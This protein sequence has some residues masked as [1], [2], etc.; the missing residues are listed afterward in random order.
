MVC[1]LVLASASPN[2]LTL[3]R[4][5]VS[6]KK[7]FQT[8]VERRGKKKSTRRRMHAKDALWARALYFDPSNGQPRKKKTD[9]RDILLH[10][11]PHCRESNQE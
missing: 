11:Q 6:L 9:K 8:K 2:R 5:I 10:A 3:L 7:L 1:R 4:Q